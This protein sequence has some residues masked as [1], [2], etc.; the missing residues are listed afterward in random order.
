[1]ASVAPIEQLQ[2]ADLT[3]RTKRAS[4]RTALHDITNANSRKRKRMVAKGLTADY[5]GNGNSNRARQP[6][7]QKTS[8]CGELEA[9]DIEVPYTQTQRSFAKP[10]RGPDADIIYCAL[11]AEDIRATMLKNEEKQRNFKSQYSFE[12]VQTQI[13]LNMRAILVDWLVEVAEEYKLRRQTLFLAV[14]Y[15]DRYT[16][17][18]TVER[19]DLQLIGITCMFIASK[20]EEIHPPPVDEFVYISDNTYTREQIITMET[21]ILVTLKFE[22]TI[23]TVHSFLSHFLVGCAVSD[24][25]QHLCHYFSETTLVHKTFWQYD[26]STIAAAIIYLALTTLSIDCS[27]FNVEGVTGYSFSSVK[28]I[29]AIICNIHSGASMSQ[30]RAVHGKYSLPKYSRVADYNVIKPMQQIL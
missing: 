12:K 30:L 27:N 19:S 11:Y 5:L 29:M 17:L 22:L 1:M 21:E 10:N 16:A 23:S 8:P 13:N 24:I 25:F 6:K 9:M 20:Y 3:S 18:R 4:R 15:V 2:G 26:P 14:H 28:H 7:N